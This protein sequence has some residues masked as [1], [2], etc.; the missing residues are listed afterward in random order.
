MAETFSGIGV[1]P[2]VALGH[3]VLHEPENLPVV[4]V[5]VPPERI[6]EEVDRFE[7]CREQARAEL[8]ELRDRTFEA[9]GES[10]A[11]MLD[12]QLLILDDPAL[13]SK[14]VQ[15]IRVGRVAARW[16]LKEVV[17][18]FMRRLEG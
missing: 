4:P 8:R 12:A 2:G 17:A 7:S 9:L 18:E 13:V 1:S 11:G 6:H 3:V 15:R 10:Y 5:P 16:A 14:T